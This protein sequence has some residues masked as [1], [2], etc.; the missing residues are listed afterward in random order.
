MKYFAKVVDGVVVEVISADSVDPSTGTWI[1]TDFNTYGGVHYSYSSNKIRQPD[2]GV[3][4]RKNFAQ[5]GYT[6]DAT[7]DAFIPPKPYASWKLNE[8]TCLWEAPIPKPTDLFKWSY[9]WNEEAQKWE[10]V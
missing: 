9:K 6:Y 2:G 4:L 7:R 1:E 10:E 5:V 3:P 8:D